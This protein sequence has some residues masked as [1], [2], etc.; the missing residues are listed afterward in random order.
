MDLLSNLLTSL[1]NAEMAG[2]SQLTVPTT[3]MNLAVLSVLKT[4]R[5]ITATAPANE[6][7]KTLVTLLS[8]VQR[9]HYKRIS[10]PSRRVYVSALQIPKVRQGRGLVILSTSGGVLIGHEAR[11]QRLGGELLCE[12]Y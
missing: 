12:V 7:R 6:E 11:A 9:H 5:I 2:L 1:R 8:P 3:K 4:A 10:K